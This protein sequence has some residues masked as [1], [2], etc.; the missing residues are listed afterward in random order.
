MGQGAARSCEWG[1]E[2]AACSQ[3]R[4]RRNWNIW[5]PPSEKRI[6][7]CLELPRIGE[8]VNREKRPRGFSVVCIK[9]R[10]LQ[11]SAPCSSVVSYQPHRLRQALCRCFVGQAQGDAYDMNNEN[12]TLSHLT[13][14]PTIL[15][16]HWLSRIL[17]QFQT[18][19]GER[20][21]WERPARDAGD[22]QWRGLPRRL[23]S[24]AGW[25]EAARGIAGPT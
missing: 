13:T 16:R 21:Q 9:I 4:M 18:L 17:E 10:L 6:S 24:D 12:T 19:Q 3:E 20:E 15:N 22:C 25:M 2:Q 11:R 1:R 7:R 14:L 8:L 23:T 5:S